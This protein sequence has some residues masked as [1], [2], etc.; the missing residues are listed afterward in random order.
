MKQHNHETPDRAFYSEG[1]TKNIHV[2]SDMGELHPYDSGKTEAKK[3]FRSKV[4][5]LSFFCRKRNDFI[6]VEIKI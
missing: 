3:N 4:R 5:S 2:E 1:L 6:F